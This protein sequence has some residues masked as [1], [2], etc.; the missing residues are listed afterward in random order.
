MMIS[1]KLLHFGVLLMIA[2]I[3]FAVMAQGGSVTFQSTQFNVVEESEKARAILAGF[4]GEISFVA[5]EEGPLID[6]LIAEGASG[7]GSTDVVGALHGTFPSLVSRD[8]LFDLSELTATLDAQYD[9]ADAFIELGK[10]GTADYQYYVPW[11]QATFV[12]AANVEALEYLPEGADLGNLTWAQL[13]EWGRAMAEATGENKVGLPVSGL[14]HRFMQGY[15]FPSF[16]GGMVTEFRSEAAV[17][18]MEYLR[19]DLWPVVNAESINYSFMQE[20]LLS[21]EVWVAFDH[22]ARLGD[23]FAAMANGET[24]LEFVA[25]PAPSGPA[26][27]GFMSVVVGLGVPFTAP[28]PDG[29]EAVI[30]FMLQ[31]ETQAQ[32][33]AELNFFPVVGGV[34][35]DSLPPRV[36]MIADAVA[37]QSAS[38]D[39][40]VALL[41][42]GLGDRGGEI[43]QIFRNVF[44]RIVQGGEAIEDVLQSEGESLNSLLSDTGAACWAPDPA[45]EGACVVK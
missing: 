6:I 32:I 18:M 16:T 45:S 36:S 8:L 22:V 13:A 10:M 11:M 31:P 17:A 27:R 28:N 38:E 1:R 15:M 19:D 26:G 9:I 40:I 21:G 23:A 29:A 12:M 41:P 2:A 30:Q 33:L 5:S 3:G 44:S 34:D 24:D 39:A 25:F 35:M 4:D 20:P 43:N 14:F 42:I 7:S 37:A